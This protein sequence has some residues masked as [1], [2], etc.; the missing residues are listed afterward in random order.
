MLFQY[1]E[2]RETLAV[3]TEYM[4]THVRAGTLSV[5]SVSGPRGKLQERHQFGICGQCPTWQRRDLFKSVGVGLDQIHLRAQPRL[6]LAPRLGGDASSAGQAVRV[7][8]HS[9]VRL[10]VP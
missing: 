7:V 8:E 10:S 4:G 1:E 2:N 6:G 5:V 9:T 3:L